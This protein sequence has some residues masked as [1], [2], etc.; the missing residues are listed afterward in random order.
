MDRRD[1]FRV[2]VRKTAEIAYRLASE[3][4]ARRAENWL[5]PPFA[6]AELDFLLACTRCDKCIE[7]CPHGVLFKLPA[8]VGPQAAGTPAMDLL[9]RGCHLCHDWPCVAACEP[10]A[11]KR[12]D[13]D[14]ET[15]PTW[16]KLA[17]VW[18]DTDTCLPYAG[19]ECGACADSCPV[20]GALQWEGGVRPVIDEDRCTGCALCREACIM[21]PK[22]VEVSAFLPEKETAE[23]S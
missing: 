20:P 1:F 13:E 10:D 22:A 21:N 11:L 15:P 23:V 2:G 3:K 9:N 6:L 16:P 19:P 4:A 17:R 8:R 7:A 18:I 5:R 14:G 12:P